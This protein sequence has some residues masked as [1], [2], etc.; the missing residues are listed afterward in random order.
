[1]LGSKQCWWRADRLRHYTTLIH[2]HIIY[3]L[4]NYPAASVVWVKRGLFA[5]LLLLLYSWWDSSPWDGSCGW[6]YKGAERAVRPG[7]S[8]RMCLIGVMGWHGYMWHGSVG[9]NY[10][11]KVKHDGTSACTRHQHKHTHTQITINQTF[12]PQHSAS[13]CNNRQTSN[14]VTLSPASELKDKVGG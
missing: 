1:M 7:Q 6:P 3:N 8:A 5:L 2:L 10:G 13:P 11:K 14:T 4:N 9:K 12:L